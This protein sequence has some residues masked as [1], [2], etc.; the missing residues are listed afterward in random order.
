MQVD[1]VIPEKK[2][3]TIRWIVNVGAMW[4]PGGCKCK[5]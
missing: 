5:L 4:E 1:P 3:V 2:I